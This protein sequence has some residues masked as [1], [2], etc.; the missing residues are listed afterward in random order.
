MQPTAQAVG[1]PKINATSPG[2]AK[3]TKLRSGKAPTSVGP[4]K[5][6]DKFGFGR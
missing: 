1:A 5:P 3:E 2:G 4:Q 6:R